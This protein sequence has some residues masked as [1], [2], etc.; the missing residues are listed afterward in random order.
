[1]KRN[2]SYKSSPIDLASLNLSTQIDLNNT[3][4][5][6]NNKINKKNIS[7]LDSTQSNESLSSLS[8]F[9][10]KSSNSSLSSSNNHN[11]CLSM[12]LAKPSLNEHKP[13]IS[14]EPK[15]KAKSLIERLV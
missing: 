2:S 5:N 8:N 1:M 12:P 13:Q 6:N 4:I 15:M 7:I 14:I 10:L 11:L 3:N 9:T